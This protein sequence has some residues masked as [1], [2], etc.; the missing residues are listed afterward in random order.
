MTQIPTVGREFTWGQLIGVMQ[1]GPYH[2][3]E[4]YPWIYVN[5]RSKH[6][7]DFDKLMFHPYVEEKDTNHSYPSL[8][9]AL[10]G[11]IAYRQEGINHR[12]DLYFIAALKE[13]GGN[14]D[15]SE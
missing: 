8:D 15:N 4:Y 5:G 2:V 1:I 13:F 9:A 6:T 12:A 11:A 10:A 7:P 14:H 3:A